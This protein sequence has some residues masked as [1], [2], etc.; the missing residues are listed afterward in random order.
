MDRDEVI[1]TLNEL[2]A[3]CKDGDEGFRTSAEAIKNPQ[4]KTFFEQK[5]RRCA[6]GAAQLQD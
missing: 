5:A 1:A 3:T 2:I 4:L 6:L